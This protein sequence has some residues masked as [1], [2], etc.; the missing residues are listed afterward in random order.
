MDLVRLEVKIPEDAHIFLKE[1]C[2]LMGVS[3]QTVIS[4]LIRQE[5]A[6]SSK[7]VTKDSGK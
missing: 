6:R 7:K 2:Y 5:M 3:M 4:L 1:R